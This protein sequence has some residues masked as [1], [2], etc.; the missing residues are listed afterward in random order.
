[1][2]ILRPWIA[3][4]SEKVEPFEYKSVTWVQNA[5][6]STLSRTLDLEKVEHFDEIG[7]QSKSAQRSAWNHTIERSLS[8]TSEFIFWTLVGQLHFLINIDRQK[9]NMVIAKIQYVLHWENQ[10]LQFLGPGYPT[11]LFA[12][13]N[14]NRDPKSTLDLILEPVSLKSPKFEPIDLKSHPQA[15]KSDPSSLN[16]TFE[17]KARALR[18]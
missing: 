1:M 9:L 10:L 11:L 5:N 17:L 12:A 18:P 13:G 4:L 15:K 3:P 16:R 7:L 6:P 8:W 2:R 14:S